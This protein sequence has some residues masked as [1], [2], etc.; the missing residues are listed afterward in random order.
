MNWQAVEVKK[1]EFKGKRMEAAAL[2][3]GSVAFIQ[4]SDSEER[5]VS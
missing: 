4:P 2:S 1:G 3:S 5:M